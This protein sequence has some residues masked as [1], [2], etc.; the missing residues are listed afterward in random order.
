[1]T[2]A[3]ATIQALEAK[4]RKIVK[5]QSVKALCESYAML[6]GRTD[7]NAATARGFIMDA[8]EAKNQDAFDAWMDCEDVALMDKPA[9]FF[10]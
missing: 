7:E 8:L 2:T 9:H 10:L 1:M 4:A 6:I 5:T 3:T